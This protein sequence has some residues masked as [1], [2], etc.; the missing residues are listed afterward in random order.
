MWPLI[1][2]KN[3]CLYVPAT[4]GITI[5]LTYSWW[6][7][8]ITNS[9]GEMVSAYW[10]YFMILTLDLIP[11][12]DIVTENRCLVFKATIPPSMSESYLMLKNALVALIGI[13]YDL[14]TLNYDYS[15][16]RSSIRRN[17]R[18]H[19]YR[20]N[21]FWTFWTSLQIVCSNCDCFIFQK[22]SV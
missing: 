7:S 6:P 8:S 21:E 18:C 22:R 14:P 16:T 20:W 11:R 1:Y 19:F 12:L 2:T 15:S 4:F 10:F 9:S 13:I 17:S 3:L 5:I